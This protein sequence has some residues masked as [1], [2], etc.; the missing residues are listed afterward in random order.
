M[1]RNGFDREMCGDYFQWVALLIYAIF[2]F[3]HVTDR[4]L[5]GLPGL[6]EALG[7][8]ACLMWCQLIHVLIR[9]CFV[10]DIQQLTQKK[11]GPSGKQ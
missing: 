6:Q 9:M 4:C 10:S 7:E 2:G 1:R 3:F 5:K 11:Y 8:W